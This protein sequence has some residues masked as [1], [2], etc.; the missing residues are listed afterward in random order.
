MQGGLNRI[1]LLCCAKEKES[2]QMKNV[3]G[4]DIAK[5]HFDVC[6]LTAEGA[7]FEEQFDNRKTGINKFHRWLKKHGAKEAHLALEATGVYGELL[8]E[9]MHSRSYEVS[10]INPARIKAYANSQM[11]RTKTDKLDAALIADYCRTQN[12]R[13]WSPPSPEVKELRALVRHF[14]D[15][16]QE[17]QRAKNRQSTQAKS[18]LVYKQLAEQIRL[19]DKQI[20]EVKKTMK[21]H[22][23]QHPHLK[24]DR[25]LLKTIPGISDIT[26]CVLL[27]ELGD[28]RRFDNVREVVA[29]LGLNPRQHQSGKLNRTRGISRMGRKSLRAALYM[30]A[31]VA[32][33]HNPIL[34]P[35][36]QALELRH[37]K[38]KQIIVAL[39]RKLVHLA[40][41]IL[42]SG[43]AFD[44][45]FGKQ[46]PIAA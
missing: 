3:V 36:A 14:E 4:I 24:Q 25:D 16:K 32:K 45:D 43:K 7:T 30:P 28:I 46:M 23:Q 6:L 39:M 26:A 40:Y 33:Q 21:K 31:V 15:L 20:D 18:S 10:I 42:K 11:R 1:K 12:P 13:L 44:P 19:L 27:A 8:A 5:E 34:K 37:L 22:I 35:W 29:F 2:K 17:R 38:G 41:G 9:T